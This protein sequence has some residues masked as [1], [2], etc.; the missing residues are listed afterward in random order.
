M[1]GEKNTE[2]NSE[3]Q[4][5]FEPTTFHTLVRC[6]NHWATEN[7][8]VSR[9]ILLLW[10]DITTA[11]RSHIMSSEHTILTV[12]CNHINSVWTMNN[13]WHDMCGKKNTE[14]NSELEMNNFIID[15]LRTRLL[16]VFWSNKFQMGI[17]F[18]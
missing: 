4:M 7:S 3:F 17:I 6:S 14:R 18:L 16:K 1:C 10:A 13:K 5:E 12:S 2:K 15:Y 9:S 11:S 8:V